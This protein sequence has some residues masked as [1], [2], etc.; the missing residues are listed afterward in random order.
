MNALRTT[1]ELQQH[2]HTD[3]YTDEIPQCMLTHIDTANKN[4]LQP[5]TP[6]ELLNLTR[7]INHFSHDLTKT[8]RP[9]RKAL[10]FYLREFLETTEEPTDILDYMKLFS[11]TNNFQ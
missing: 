1:L 6:M 4:L 5:Y 7:T 8:Q 3:L 11:N 9:L 2:Y 10:C